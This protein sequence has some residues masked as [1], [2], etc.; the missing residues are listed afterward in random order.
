MAAVCVILVWGA[1]FGLDIWT[2]HGKVVNVPNVS[3]LTLSQARD[4]L[5]SADLTMELSDSVY[6]DNA[7][8]GS[9]IEQLPRE[10]DRVK[11]GRTVYLTINAFSPKTLSVP[12]LTGVSFRQARSVLES[13]GFTNVNVRYIPSEYKDLV[14]AVKFNGL[15]LRAGTRLPVSSTITIEVGEGFSDMTLDSIAA[16]GNPAGEHSDDNFESPLVWD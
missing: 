1:L 8:P 2:G 15:P 5:E 7:V 3:G 13:L 14:L 16:I 11:P 4:V 10:G 6:S 12:E 9:V